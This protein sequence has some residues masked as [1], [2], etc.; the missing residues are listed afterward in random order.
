[1]TADRATP[2]AP[3][4][5][6]NVTRKKLDTTTGYDVPSACLGFVEYPRVSYGNLVRDFE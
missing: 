4:N 6:E 3:I 5:A 1:M 2:P